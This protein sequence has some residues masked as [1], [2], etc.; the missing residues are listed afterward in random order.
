MQIIEIQPLENGA[1]RNQEGEFPSVPD[2]WAVIPPSLSIPDTFPFVELTVEG[3]AVIAIE[4]GTVPE[5][6]P[7]PEP[8]PTAE[9]QLRADVDYIAAM[10]GVEL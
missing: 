5:P 6:E 1:H 7:T 9:E 2:G 10:T 4:P 8:P 3:Q